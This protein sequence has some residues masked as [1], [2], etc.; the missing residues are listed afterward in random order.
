MRKTFALIMAAALLAGSVQIALG[1]DTPL[2]QD[3]QRIDG[4][5]AARDGRGPGPGWGKRHGGMHDGRHGDFRRGDAGPRDWGRG[6][7][8]PGRFGGCPAFGGPRHQAGP[9]PQFG[10]MGM[11][12][13]QGFGRLPFDQLDLTA[14]QKTKLIDIATNN[15][16]AGLEAKVEMMD[17][18]K[19]LRDMR[20]DKSVSADAIIQ[21]NTELGAAKGKME[22]LRRQFRDDVEKVLTPDQLKTL[23]ERR[24]GPPPPPPGD[25]RLGDGR[26]GPGPRG[27][28]RP[29]ERMPTPGPRR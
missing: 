11:G 10:G 5:M 26:P 23:E 24:M 3:D 19:K 2:P 6:P 16:R 17:A 8:G 20:D 9:G 21:A 13:G 18:H 22:V 4:G 15:F 27:P 12:M 7:G 25:R 14:G 29:G 28:G 1:E